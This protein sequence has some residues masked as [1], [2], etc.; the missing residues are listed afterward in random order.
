M[1]EKKS[2][3]R[4]DMLR[5]LAVLIKQTKHLDYNPSESDGAWV[6]GDHGVPE[7]AQGDCANLP[8]PEPDSDPVLAEF[9]S[10]ADAEFLRVVRPYDEGRVPEMPEES[11]RSYSLGEWPV[12]DLI[13]VLERAETDVR[14]EV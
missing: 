12:G 2:P 4:T 11:F 1:S 3:E 6:C 13:G 9:Q 7:C 10:W 8:W 5:H 14:T